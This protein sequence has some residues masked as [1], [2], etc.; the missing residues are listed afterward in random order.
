M[1]IDPIPMIS[2]ESRPIKKL[3]N[4]AKV[5]CI[6]GFD[7]VVDNTDE[8]IKIAQQIGYPVMI[9]ASA[10]GGG[11]GIYL[12]DAFSYNTRFKRVLRTNARTCDHLIVISYKEQLVQQDI[13]RILVHASLLDERLVETAFIN[14]TFS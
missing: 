2:T 5:N 4:K 9:K 3:A 1:S 8:A 13:R 14:S 6:P 11:K 7:G 12:A 10:G